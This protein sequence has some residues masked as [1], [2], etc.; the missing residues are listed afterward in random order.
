MCL[1]L[2][3]E[4]LNSVFSHSDCLR[5]YG[6]NGKRETVHLI[7]NKFWARVI[8]KVLPPSLNIL[9]RVQRYTDLYII[10]EAGFSG[11]HCHA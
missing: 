6:F 1:H 2:G 7:L 10:K 4:G 8:M 9:T 11:Y 5:H 3:T